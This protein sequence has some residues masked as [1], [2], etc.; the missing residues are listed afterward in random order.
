MKYL[1]ILFLL[2]PVSV[3]AY[4]A[5]LTWTPPTLNDDGTPLVDLAGYIIYRGDES[6]VYVDSI[7]LNDPTATSYVWTGLPA[8]SHYF[9]ATAFNTAGTES[10]FS[11][12]ASKTFVV[13][14][15]PPTGLTAQGDLVA[16]AP[17]MTSDRFVLIPVGTVPEGTA[18]DGSQSANGKYLIPRDSVQWATELNRP[19]VVFT[20]CSPG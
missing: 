1:A 3:F 4:D 9:V 12:E 2:L 18:C 10:V 19:A 15:E 6:G 20:D 17:S 14:P 8:G 16:Y 7:T 11:V 13:A 5:T